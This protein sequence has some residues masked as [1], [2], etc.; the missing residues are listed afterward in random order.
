MKKMSFF[1]KL[2]KNPSEILEIL[3]DN[4]AILEKQ[5]KN[6]ENALEEVPK[7]LKA[8]KE[9]LCGTNDKEHQ[10]KQWLSWHKNTTTVAAGIRGIE[11]RN[12]LPLS[13]ITSSLLLLLFLLLPLP[14]PLLPSSIFLL[15][16]ET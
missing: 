13:Y 11:P 16:V 2:Q 6:T 7:S 14:L 9:I 12:A 5:D 10:Q 1:S 4:I 8:M 15:H 3:K